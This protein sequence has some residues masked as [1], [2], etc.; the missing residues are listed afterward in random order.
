MAAAELPSSAPAEVRR[1]ERI[2]RR[3]LAVADLIAAIVATL[4]AL[5]VFGDEIPTALV[6]AMPLLLVFAAKLA[7]LYERDEVVLGSRLS[8]TRRCSSG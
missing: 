7:G 5:V 4:T 1:R 6:F 8:R 2:Q 3:A